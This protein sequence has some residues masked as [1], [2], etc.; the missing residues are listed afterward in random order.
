MRQFS[1]TWLLL[2]SVFVGFAQKGKISGTV[3]NFIN[4]ETIPLATIQI[5]ETKQFVNADFDGNYEFNNLEP[6][7][8]SL[9]AVFT[10]FKVKTIYEIKVTNSQPAFVDIY[11]EED[12]QL[13][14][15][16]VVENKKF[17]KT[18][19]LYTSPSPRD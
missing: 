15:E 14:G 13:L 2:L 1:I 11:L 3:Y 19:L 17:D 12:V 18:C 8:Y 4:K 10:G 6:G 9:Q 16:V 7:L 5:M